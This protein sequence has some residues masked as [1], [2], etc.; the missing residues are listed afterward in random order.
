MTNYTSALVNLWQSAQERQ[1]K[2]EF[3]RALDANPSNARRMRDWR[4]SKIFRFFGM[5][6]KPL[7]GNQ[8]ARKTDKRIKNLIARGLKLKC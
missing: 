3:I 4:W 1:D 2:Y 7:F 5:I 8:K 6:E